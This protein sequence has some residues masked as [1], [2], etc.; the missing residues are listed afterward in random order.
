[1]R[2]TLTEGTAGDMVPV[3]ATE[4]PRVSDVGETVM[5]ML[6][7]FAPVITGELGRYLVGRA[8][9][10]DFSEPSPT[11]SRVDDQELRRR[12]LSLSQSEASKLGIGKST[13]YHLRKI[14][15]TGHAFRVRQET[16]NK[17]RRSTL[18]SDEIMKIYNQISLQRM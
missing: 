7:G 15:R 9:M 4:F 14:A 8:G 13:I 10:L 12:I 1:M 17:L 11:L 6:L 3:T 5:D 16:L 2:V 18:R